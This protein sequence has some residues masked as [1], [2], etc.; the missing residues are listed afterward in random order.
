ME[1]DANIQPLLDKIKREGIEEAK[2]AKDETLQSAHKEAEVIIKDAK[3]QAERMIREAKSEIQRNQ[4]IYKKSMAI[5]GRDLISSLRNQIIG[6]FNHIL[7]RQTD[8]ALT[9]EVMKEMILKMIDKWEIQNQSQ[10]IEILLSKG[11]LG[12]LEK[13]LFTSVKNELKKGITLE[14]IEGI[15]AGFRIGEKDGTMHYDFSDRVITETLME[16]LSPN[17]SKFLREIPEE[18]KDQT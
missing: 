8:I 2:R 3:E 7:A 17:I 4:D 5:A 11:D 10:A 6:L 1:P 16:Y 15:G 9:P 18:N 13:Q 12:K 14:P